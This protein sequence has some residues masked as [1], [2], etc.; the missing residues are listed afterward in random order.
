MIGAMTA[1]DPARPP[2][3]RAAV[4]RALRRTLLCIRAFD[5]AE[6]LEATLA[7]LRVPP[8]IVVVLDRA[9]SDETARICARAGI[10]R[11]EV[12]PSR[13]VA[14]SCN[15]GLDLAR[16]RDCDFVLLVASGVRFVTDVA[17]ELVE[18]ALA[19]AAVAAV[20]PSRVLVDRA[21][22]AR[23]LVYRAGW[24][25]STVTFAGDESHPHGDPRQLE[26]DYG[27]WACALLRIAAV[28]EV[29]GFDERYGDRHGDADLG[30]RLRQAGHASVAL[31]HAQVRQEQGADPAGDDAEAWRSRA[32]FV[33]TW[34]GLGLGRVARPRAGTVPWSTV[35]AQLHETLRRHGLL[36][37]DR[38]PLVLGPPGTTPFGYLHTGCATDRVP[39]A[40]RQDLERHR[41]VL[42]PSRWVGEVVRASSAAE[43][44]TVPL[45]IDPDVFH[46]WAGAERPSAEPTFLW[47]GRAE[48][49]TGL[50]VMLTAW[51]R[52]L[53][54]M[55]K[56][57]LV[58]M[59]TGVLAFGGC[60]PAGTRAWKEFL[61]GD[62]DGRR[63]SYREVIGPLSDRRRA[64]LYRG[65]DALVCTSRSESFGLRIAEAMACG[66]A[67]VLPA[68]GG[69]RD[70][71]HEG[72][73]G[74]GGRLTVAAGVPGE[75]GRWWEPE[76]DAIV[77]RMEEACRPDGAAGR[78]AGSELVR[79]RFTWRRTAFHLRSCLADLQERRD[80]SDASDP[81]ARTAADLFTQAL[82]LERDA[83][84]GPAAGT[85][86]RLP[87]RT[88]RALAG[89]DPAFY[90]SRNE[91]V[92]AAG[93]DPLAHYVE[94]G[95]REDRDPS[96]H[97]STGQ[98]IRAHPEARRVLLER[99]YVGRPRTVLGIGIG[100]R[101]AAGPTLPPL[102]PRGGRRAPVARKRGILLTGYV[103]AWLGLGQSARGLARA[104]EEAGL[105]FA[106]YPNNRHV[107]ERFIGRFMES[108]YDLRAAY[109][110]NV[111][112][113]ALEQ[114]P[115]AMEE[116][117]PARTGASHNIL[118]PYW[119]LERL[120]PAMA[121]FLSGIHEV[122]APTTFVAEAFRALFPGPVVLVPPVVD[123]SDPA[124]FGRERF[125][126]EEGRFTILVTF[127]YNSTATRK[128]P[129]GAIRAFQAAFPDR[130]EPVVLVVK[131]TG[132]PDTWPR[133]R[134]EIAA[135]REGDSRIVTLDGT[136]PRAEILALM[137]ACDLYLSL[138]R[139]EGF[140]LGMAEA[141]ALGKPVVATDYAG[142]RDFLTPE[143]G[144][145]VAVAMRRLRDGEYP[146][147]DG[148]SW[149]EPVPEAAAAALRE[150]Y[151]DPEGRARRA[152]TGQLF[153]REHHGR[154]AVG[155]I[156][157]RLL[158]DRL[159]APRWGAALLDR[160]APRRE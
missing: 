8:D 80:R 18:A 103:E 120:P 66:T 24:D 52:L 79:S 158:S 92:A 97:L 121:G 51:D 46:P 138:H 3:G 153:V 86:S 154:A 135:A 150:G 117:G 94:H 26:A 73:L 30:F 45:G 49:R 110:V 125:G 151:R 145:P 27:D 91:D 20:A 105:P 14:A 96:P 101:P 90:A 123:V 68:Y 35:D 59:G 29:G 124:P 87:R 157:R 159:P 81:A 131:S 82:R 15:I 69:C 100:H 89:F 140:G 38:P 107:R 147:G 84:S 133:A 33:R 155:R 83:V 17:R 6:A 62:D 57:R 1:R 61:V 2:E 22:G 54:R 143:T 88:R 148:Q 102:P 56:A 31:P 74:F 60:N 23:R 130:S 78:E 28:A 76:V 112:E 134:A 72:S 34:L 141:M 64:A 70:L 10:E 144:Y 47:L 139:S 39:E 111:I 50:D 114:L 53:A 12:E 122:W 109:D 85:R 126:L 16:Q 93:L 113:L 146:H 137:A 71:A 104:M 149:A 4:D 156:L 95:W 77:L 118:R 40:W 116:L 108:R 99:A 58:V 7:T 142:S 160:I 21:T 37:P 67:V 129:L 5:G 136:M 106:L 65:V 32:V 55:P 48:P 127:D 36:D 63:I 19:N 25:L 98:L 115:E 75:A 43:P 132:E 152:R 44:R 9:G 13:S 119:E 11:I 42:V 128:N 41:A